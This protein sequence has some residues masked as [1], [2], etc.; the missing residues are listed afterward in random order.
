MS[1]APYLSLVIPAYNEQENIPV[2]LERVGA[3]LAQTGR[4]FEVLIVDDGSSD[5]TL[6]Y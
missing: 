5:S 3:S 4:P 6:Y 1:D 2:L